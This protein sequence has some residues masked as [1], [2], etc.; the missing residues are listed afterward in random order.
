MGNGC[1]GATALGG[2]VG[3]GDLFP[4]E[5]VAAHSTFEDAD[6]FFTGSPGGPTEPGEEGW[7]E[8]VARE[9]EFE[10]WS[11]MLDAALRS[12]QTE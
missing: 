5:W 8:Y 2:A 4:D 3:T 6:S 10:D 7:N 9:T 12:Y 1:D 11:A